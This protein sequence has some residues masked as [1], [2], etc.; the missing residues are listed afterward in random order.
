MK[1]SDKINFQAIQDY[2]NGLK[3]KNKTSIRKKIFWAVGI[4]F[5]IVISI[6]VGIVIWYNSQLAPVGGDLND[7]IKITVTTGSTSSQIAKELEKQKII[8]SSFAFEMYVRLSGNNSKLQAGVYRL[9]PAES[10]RQIVEHFTNGSVDKFNITFLPGATLADA[11][12][13]LKKASYSD[14]EITD[15]L[16]IK[17]DSP[18]FD[19]K[20][21]SADL[22]GYIYGETYNFNIGATV[23]DILNGI[24]DE[25]YSKVKENNLVSNFTKHDLN[26]YQ[27]ITLASIVEREVITEKDQKQAAQVFYSRLEQGMQLGSD[28]TYQ[29]I[30]DKL[31]LE[32]DPNLDNPYNTRRFVGLPPGPISNPGLMALKAVANPAS[33]DYIYFLSGDDDVTYFA[34]TLAEHES[35]IVNHCKIKCSTP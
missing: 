5:A 4:F 6:I 32:R 21:A 1:I 16:N 24:F 28:V 26:L 2:L 15:A 3:I 20:P 27:A 10:T 23:E 9:S 18:L 22:E 34:R 33:G 35:N 29:Y 8:R 13:V 17:Y 14:Q 25:F 31:G 11:I 12:K 19:G 7:K 30:A